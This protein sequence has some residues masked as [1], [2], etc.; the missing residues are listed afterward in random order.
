M[1]A[2]GQLT[3]RIEP[4]QRLRFSGPTHSESSRRKGV[5][6][7]VETGTF[8]ANRFHHPDQERRAKP[9]INDHAFSIQAIHHDDQILRRAN[10][11]SFQ[12]TSVANHGQF[13]EGRVEQVG[14]YVAHLPQGCDGLKIPFG[15]RQRIEQVYQFF[16]QPAKEMG[17]EDRAKPLP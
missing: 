8:F 4:I 15:G 5:E 7:F 2:L 14:C 16:V 17:A 11:D 10:I 9:P 1:P 13:T 12:I 3:G 6:S